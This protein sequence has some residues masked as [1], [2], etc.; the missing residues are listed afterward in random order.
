MMPAF[1][2][3]SPEERNGIVSFLSDKE[4][5]TFKVADTTAPMTVSPY[6]HS[7]YERWYDRNGYPVNAP[8]WGTLTAINLQSG[9]QLWQ[10]PLGEFPSLTE[11]GIPP[12]GT[13][14][15]GGPLVTASGL[16]FIAA[17]TDKKFRAFDTENGD[18]LWET[19]LPAAGYASPST[20]AVKN[21]QYVV[22]ACGGGKFKTESG[23]KY[24]AFAIKE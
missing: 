19:V 9:E 1:S 6:T 24:V 20:Y 16:V 22:I 11:K 7:G 3:I 2:H 4:D 13:D 10:V 8:P 17:T 12:T 23:D 14:N 21:K 15:H 5:A 18:I